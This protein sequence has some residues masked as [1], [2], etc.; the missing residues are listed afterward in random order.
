MPH[1]FAP[2]LV[3]S[4]KV[5]LPVI[6]RLLNLYAK[7]FRSPDVLTSICSLLCWWLF[8]LSPAGIY[9]P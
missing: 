4:K 5:I 7:T 8:F 3:G 9:A 2:L 6:D 1:C